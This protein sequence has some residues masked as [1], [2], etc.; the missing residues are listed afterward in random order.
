VKGYTHKLFTYPAFLTNAGY[1]C[2]YDT[3]LAFLAQCCRVQE[4]KKSLKKDEKPCNSGHKGRFKC[5]GWKHTSIG[6]LF[7]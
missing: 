4:T 1:G 6:M 2:Q 5:F 7:A 3:R